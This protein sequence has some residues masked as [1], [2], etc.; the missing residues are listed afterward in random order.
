MG[1]KQ[2]CEPEKKASA[3]E[4]FAIKK[5]WVRRKDLIPAA[6]RESTRISSPR[7]STPFQFQPSAGKL[8]TRAR[9][10]C[11]GDLRRPDGKNS[12]VGNYRFFSQ[13]DYA[14]LLW[15]EGPRARKKSLREGGFCDQS[16]LAPAEGLEPPA[17]WLTATCSTIELRRKRAQ[18]YQNPPALSIKGSFL[19]SAAHL[20]IFPP[21]KTYYNLR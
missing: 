15:P 1:S 2:G 17:S 12:C 19:N 11:A 3:M 21:R 7:R 9:R 13:T 8:V 6:G 16:C 14:D 4:A 10:V 18:F 5:Y 20:V